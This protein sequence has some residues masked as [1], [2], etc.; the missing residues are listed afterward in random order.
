[1]TTGDK[2]LALRPRGESN[3]RWDLV[4]FN[5][6][7]VTSQAFL[8]SAIRA[9]LSSPR[10][11]AG[12]PVGERWSGSITVNPTSSSDN[13]IRI[14]SVPFVGLDANGGLVLKPNGVTLATA[15]PSGGSS[16]QV[17][18]YM[19]DVAMNTQLR[20]KLPATTPFTEFSA[21]INVAFQ[22]QANIYI[23]AGGA[24]SVIPSD[25]ISNVTTPLL[26]LGIATNTAGIVTFTP[27]A[28]MLE[29]VTQPT[30]VPAT[31]T[32]T[33]AAGT[34]QTGGQATLRELTNA[35]LYGLG[36]A[37]WKGSDFLTPSASNNFGAYT[38]P[39]GGVDKAFRQALKMITIGDGVSTFGDFNIADYPNCNSMLTA[40]FA[41]LPSQGGR[42]WL[43]GVFL[44]GFNGVTVTLPAGQT[45]EIIGDHSALPN[46][47]PQ[48]TFAAGESFTCSA[49]GKLI[50]RNLHVRYAATAVF[51]TSAPLVI[52]D[53]YF[54]ST[55][56]TD[57]G[58][59]IQ[60][61]GS[62]TSVT[63]VD[64][65]GMTLTTLQSTNV[66]TG[67]GLRVTTI[68]CRRLRLLHITHNNAQHECGTIQLTD[69]RE[70]VEIGFITYNWTLG[71]T[72]GSTVAIVA[73]DTTDNTTDVRRRY[74]HDICA[75]IG[76][77][78]AIF[79][80]RNVGHLYVERLTGAT[81]FG[82]HTLA[83]S[84]AA[85]PTLYRDCDLFSS[86]VAATS[87]AMAGQVVDLTF[88]T[89]SFGN[90]V[91]VG[92]DQTDILTKV[93]FKN[94][95][96][97]APLTKVGGSSVQ[98]VLV[99]SCRFVNPSN[100][101]DSNFSAFAVLSLSFAM[102]VVFRNNIIDGI[103]NVAY[104]G[105][106]ATTASR[107][108]EVDAT[109]IGQII[110]AN[111]VMTSALSG[112][113]GNNQLGAYL[114]DVSSSDRV[115]AN[116]SAARI[117]VSNNNIGD[118]SSVC[119]LLNVTKFTA[120]NHVVINDNV[121]STSYLTGIGPRM[122]H[123]VDLESASG[124]SPV[125]VFRFFGNTVNLQLAASV[126]ITFDIV[127]ANTS[128]ATWSTLSLDDNHIVLSNNTVWNMTTAWGFNFTGAF[129]TN[130]S[131]RGNIVALPTTT[132]TNFFASR[133]AGSVTRT[134]PTGGVPS[135]G[136][137]WAEN[138][139]IV[140]A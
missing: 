56:T 21:A 120:L 114:L 84:I 28:N 23:R 2:A 85:G 64:V 109:G 88:D 34:T 71:V 77:T 98:S 22:Q 36:Q 7:S 94:C 37:S 99:E 138:V 102:S 20:R 27:A 121:V 1:M 26:F 103:Q 5:A 45:V 17:Y 3:E 78:M 8:E 81:R 47:L 107:A 131:V 82:I 11:T 105:S 33:T 19:A 58:A 129:I 18:L 63:D 86:S 60:N 42:I 135:T 134:L 10:A 106:D 12:S 15:V 48:I 89:C 38:I 112:A 110:C 74:V 111:N 44:S 40:A 9:L 118:S 125:N 80:N 100:A 96:F 51:V 87:V 75:N 116:M 92:T 76:S 126:Q 50:L 93:Q 101:A 52:R 35:T 55:A 115:T 124:A 72:I 4:D 117:V 31:S 122:S 79:E 59:A 70:D 83:P 127:R 108:F 128:T 66:G 39:A 24:G 97:L 61:A 14:D 13:L 139:Q 67:M 25:A 69:I 16:Q 119:M 43:K 133:F 90:F 132:L 140:G 53:V 91:A 29:T 113:A 136:V 104:T 137:Y 6:M 46:T 41:A 57:T 32:G 65:D 30:S 123:I 95:T 54:E 68:P 49:T 62:A 130:L 73:I